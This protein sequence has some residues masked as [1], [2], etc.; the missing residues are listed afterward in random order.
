M[1]KTLEPAAGSVY[2]LLANSAPPLAVALDAV[3]GFMDATRIVRLPLCPPSVVGLCSYR[4]GFIPAIRV[5]ESIGG[6]EQTSP[7][8]ARDAAV[9]VLRTPHG[10]LGLIIHREGVSIAEDCAIR[11]RE[12]R[13]LPTG[14]VTGGSL[15]QN[16]TSFSVLD[17]ALTWRAL[18]ETLDDWHGTR[19]DEPQSQVLGAAQVA[20]G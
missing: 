7:E 13:R 16:G 17:T 14:F 4:G 15:E 6:R 18:R 11:T 20:A 19:G 2:C 8:P 3:V 9:L 1:E 10:E 12:A 5:A